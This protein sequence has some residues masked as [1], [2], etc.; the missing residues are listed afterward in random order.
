MSFNLN[1]ILVITGVVVLAFIMAFI[2]WWNKAIVISNGI[3]IINKD[4]TTKSLITGLDCLNADVRPIAVMLSSDLETRPLSGISQAD[5]VFEMPVAP[6]G[7]ARFMAIFQ[8]EKPNE[9]GSIRSARDD[10]IPLAAAFGSLYVHWGGEFG[11]LEKLNSHIVDNID[12][13]KYEGTVFYRKKGAPLPHNGFTNIDLL[14]QT[15]KFLGYNLRNSFSGYPHQTKP[16]IKNLNNIV[17]N[18]TVD[19]PSAFYN[20]LVEWSYDRATN[21]YLR[22]RGGT[23]EMDKNSNSQVRVAVVIIMKTTSSSLRDQYINVGVTGEGE[24]RVFQNGTEIR[25]RWKKEGIE[26]KLYF[27]NNSGKEIEFVPGKIWVEVKATNLP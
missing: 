9:I 20:N 1:K 15:A 12:G 22:S 6:N 2:V 19:Y 16:P 8:C 24:I 10:F 5:M 13:L 17:D 14:T 18:I 26:G 21:L 7:F 25:G 23:M 4:E 11:A 27:F 3:S